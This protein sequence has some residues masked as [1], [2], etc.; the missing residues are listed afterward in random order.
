MML[1]III[2][3][4]ERHRIEQYFSES[5]RD[6]RFYYQFFWQEEMRYEIHI[7]PQFMVFIIEIQFV[8]SRS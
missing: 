7:D 6:L 2:K 3:S 5:L 4:F 1:G 8:I